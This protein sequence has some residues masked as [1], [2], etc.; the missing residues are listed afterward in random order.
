MGDEQPLLRQR[1][2]CF[3]IQKIFLVGTGKMR[4]PTVVLAIDIHRRRRRLPRPVG[5]YFDLAERR[6]RIWAICV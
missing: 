3:D 6:V 2:G 5:R 4:I 1:P